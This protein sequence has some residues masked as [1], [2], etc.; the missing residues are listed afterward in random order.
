MIWN[1][2]PYLGQIGY[3]DGKETGHVELS[4]IENGEITEEER[5]DVPL[6]H[7]QICS[8]VKKG[9][10]TFIGVKYFKLFKIQ[11]GGK[12]EEIDCV[13]GTEVT[14]VKKAPSTVNTET[15]QGQAAAKG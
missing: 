6:K 12:G 13:L 10:E 2:R 9:G 11:D 14:E 15:A 5:L 4:S 8:F 3:A 7:V 1:D